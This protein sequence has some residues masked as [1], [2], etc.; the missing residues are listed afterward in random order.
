MESNKES[1]IVIGAGPA[2]LTSAYV[3]LKRSNGKIKPLIFEMDPKYVGGISRTEEYK[4]YKFDIGG[5]RFFSKSQEIEDLWTEMAGDVMLE[6]PRLSRIYYQKDFYDYPIKPFNAFKNL[7]LISTIHVLISYAWIRLFP[8]KDPQTFEDWVTNQFGKKLYETFFK[9]YSEKV[10]GMPCTEISA[11]WAAQRIK[12]LS[13]S[14]L[15][16]TTIKS[17]FDFKKKDKDGDVIKTL[18]TQF[19]YPKQGP[20]QLWELVADKIKDMG[21]KIK[22]GTRVT[23]INYSDDKKKIK[24]IV[25][26]DSN[27]NEKEY[28]ADHFFSTMPMRNLI[29]SMDPKP[30]EKIKEAASILRYRDFVTVILIVNKKELFPDNWIYVHDPEVKLGRVQNFK[31]WSPHMVPDE[32]KSSLGLEYFCFEGDEFWNMKNEDL[33]K[34]AKEEIEKIGL[35]DS[36]LVEDGYVVQMPKAYPIYDQNY[37]RAVGTIRGFTD[38]FENLH[39]VGRNGMHRYNNQDHSMMSAIIAVRKMLGEKDLDPWG[40]N[41]DA[42]YHE[43]MKEKETKKL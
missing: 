29:N 17:M 8:I 14:S 16:A 31:N 24:S 11:D 15:I 25:A 2:G 33:I 21:G 4:G 34:L 20:G 1:M 41:E 12:G 22:M 26:I 27:G 10:W 3:A 18:I 43:T 39:L 6:R 19:R 38:E 30:D 35:V 13:I 23:K 42:E 37:G 28:F 40:V 5:H 32:S 7:G 36:S 9:T